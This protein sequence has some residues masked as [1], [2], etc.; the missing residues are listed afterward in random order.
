M[1]LLATVLVWFV[2]ADPLGNIVERDTAVLQTY[3]PDVMWEIDQLYMLLETARRVPPLA[4]PLQIPAKDYSNNPKRLRIL[5]VGDSFVDGV[6]ITN[7]E[8]RFAPSLERELE[9]L[10]G[11]GSVEVV[12]LS[13]GGAS[14]FS[15]AKWM[16]IHKTGEKVSLDNTL[17]LDYVDLSGNF[18]ATVLAFTP[19][20]SI[21]GIEWL[22]IPEIVKL[23]PEEEA[24]VLKG[25]MVDPNQDLLLKSIESFKKNSPGSTKIWYDLNFNGYIKGRPQMAPVFEKYGYKIAP[26]PNLDA[27]VKKT[28]PDKLFS[29]PAENHPTAA[30][31]RAY[32]MD[33]ATFIYASL[34]KDRIKEAAAS[35][36]ASP[37]PIVSNYL[38]TDIKVSSDQKSAEL[39]YTTK[40]A[41]KCNS[42]RSNFKPK[43]EYDNRSVSCS[44]DAP[45]SLPK[46]YLEGSEIPLVLMPCAPLGNP[47]L[48]VFFSQKGLDVSVNVEQTG[49]NISYLDLYAILE[50]ADGFL[51][52]E[53]KKQV[54]LNPNP[55][56]KVA[57]PELVGFA[58]ANPQLDCKPDTVQEFPDVK[59]SVKLFG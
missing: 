40:N 52:F 12:S 54:G 25:E 38:P 11:E 51:R 45:E 56:V 22:D 13:Q 34:P 43:F 2:Y 37:R 36:V 48:S 39:S 27:L 35:A 41:Q 8:S 31:V 30:V 49:K 6:G 55:Q 4:K 14:M 20:D 59:I 47:H 50:D 17:E 3:N 19:N 32:S 44:T 46:Y 23:S 10:L 33:L 24:S 42:A 28:E 9:N 1:M 53:K 21:P 29:T 58:V 18:D 5:L 26:T 57:S 7:L 15:Y 16:E